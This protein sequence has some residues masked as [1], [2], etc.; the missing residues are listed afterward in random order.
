VVNPLR[1]DRFE[2]RVTKRRPKPYAWL[3]SPCQVM[4]GTLLLWLPHAVEE[5]FGVADTAVTERA[6]PYELAG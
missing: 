6:L 1:P 3:T 5:T 4:R 2:P